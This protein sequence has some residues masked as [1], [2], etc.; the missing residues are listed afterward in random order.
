MGSSFWR[1]VYILPWVL[2]LAGAVLNAKRGTLAGVM[3]L[4]GASVMCGC[5]VIS[6]SLVSIVDLDETNRPGGRVLAFS[7]WGYVNQYF[8][9]LAGEEIRNSLRGLDRNSDDTMRRAA[10][11]ALKHVSTLP[12]AHYAIPESTPNE[13]ARGTGRVFDQEHIQQ[14]GAGSMFKQQDTSA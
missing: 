1:V 3:Q 2:V 5:M 7:T 14:F 4:A 10:Q 13:S 11:V 9:A 6:N 8:C 12:N